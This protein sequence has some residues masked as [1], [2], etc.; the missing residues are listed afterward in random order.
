MENEKHCHHGE[1][2]VWFTIEQFHFIFFFNKMG[3]VSF[4]MFIWPYDIFH[5]HRRL[6]SPYILSIETVTV[7]CWRISQPQLIM[8]SFVTHTY[9]WGCSEVNCDWSYER[10]DRI[11]CGAVESKLSCF[12][13]N[14][15][16]IH[17][18]FYCGFVYMQYNAYAFT[19][20]C[21]KHASWIPG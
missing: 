19:T 7:N 9:C 10:M 16:R 15:Y 3:W 2:L 14:W 8:S 6:L 11:G 4:S 13:S 12:Q 1:N 5:V 17:L 21:T 20:I 18:C